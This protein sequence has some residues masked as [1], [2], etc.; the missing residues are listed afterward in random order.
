MTYKTKTNCL[1]VLLLLGFMQLLQSATAQDTSL[2]SSL[3]TRLKPEIGKE[4]VLVVTKNG[5][6][7]FKKEEGDATTS[8][9]MPIA[10]CSQWLT[11][12]MVMTFVQEGKLRL[13][14]KIADYIPLFKTYGKPY[15]TLK[16]CLT[17]QTGIEQKPTTSSNSITG[18]RNSSLEEEVNAFAN[19]TEIDFNPGDYFFYG[20][21]GLNIAA[22]VCEIISKR[23][24]EQLMRDRIFK[25]LKMNTTTIAE[26]YNE[27]PNPSGSMQSTATE[28]SNF[29]NMLLN[30]GMFNGKQILTEASINSMITLQIDNTKIKYV[31][32]GAKGF[33]YGLGCWIQKMAVN[34]K[35]IVVSTP[36]LF[37]SL[38]LANFCKNYTLVIFS[39]KLLNGANREILKKLSD[40]IEDAME[41]KECGD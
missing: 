41:S 5:K 32:E 6:A 38:V 9:L 21:V 31:P 36:S 14:T 34:N 37:G 29:L 28:Y 17:H 26:S 18:K 13:D 11:A 39:K 10:N 35:A 19:K 23:S 40:G 30:K 1:K 33:N 2:I 4:F 20:R 8:T 7:I 16:D 3:V 22:R 27:A 24:F 25:P 12:A 15:I